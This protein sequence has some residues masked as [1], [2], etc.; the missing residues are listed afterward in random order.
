MRAKPRQQGRNSGDPGGYFDDSLIQSSWARVLS[1]CQSE[2]ATKRARR[3]IPRQTRMADLLRARTR[4]LAG[5]F[6]LPLIKGYAMGMW[7]TDPKSANM[8]HGKK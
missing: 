7:K 1:A 2:A 6:S 4:R 5:S 8:H 3:I